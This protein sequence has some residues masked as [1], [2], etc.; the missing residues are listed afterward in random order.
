MRLETEDLFTEYWQSVYAAAYIVCRDRMD[1]EDVAQDTFVKYFMHNRQFES[2]EHIKAWLLRTAINRARDLTR[3]FYRKNK[4]P[5]EEYMSGAE[6]TG[7][8]DQHF[9]RIDEQQQ[10]TSAV[11]TLPEKYRIVVHLFYYEDHSCSEIAGMLHLSEANVRKRLCRARDM[12]KAKMMEEW[13][14]D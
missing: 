9:C 12:L 10:L 4:V 6:K 7:S 14:D 1:A 5:L 3:S 2:K 11:M 8:V 13:E